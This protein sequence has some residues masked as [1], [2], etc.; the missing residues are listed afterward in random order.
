MGAGER[1]L[2]GFGWRQYGSWARQCT[3]IG[4]SVRRV[5]VH[6]NVQLENL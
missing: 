6:A 3:S 5:V 1:V 2:W 4:H